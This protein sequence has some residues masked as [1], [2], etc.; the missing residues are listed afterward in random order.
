M[1]GGPG[2]DSYCGQT[3]LRLAEGTHFSGQFFSTLL[4]L[5]WPHS[6]GLQHTQE[7]ERWA[8]AYSVLPGSAEG[9]QVEMGLL[10]PSCLLL[11]WQDT[12]PSW[13]LPSPTQVLLSSA[14]CHLVLEKSQ[15]AAGLDDSGHGEQGEAM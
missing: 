2:G 13:H 15:G 8:R 9:I 12:W 4:Y 3:G 11:S 7:G 10:F 5:G 1:G 14:V 6:T